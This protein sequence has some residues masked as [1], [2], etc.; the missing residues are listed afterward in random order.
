ILIILVRLQDVN[1][2][3]MRVHSR[4]KSNHVVFSHA[5][6]E[7]RDRDEFILPP[8]PALEASNEQL[9]I[10]DTS[11]SKFCASDELSQSTIPPPCDFIG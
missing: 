1:Q 9:F 11:S 6:A 4:K 5:D 8:D 2:G 7:P 3:E 10:G